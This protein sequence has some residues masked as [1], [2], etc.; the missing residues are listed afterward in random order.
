MKAIK[1]TFGVGVGLLACAALPAHAEAGSNLGFGLKAHI[2]PSSLYKHGKVT[3]P[4][5]AQQ[6]DKDQERG[7]GWFGKMP[8]YIGGYVEYAFTDFLGLELGLAYTWQGGTFKGKEKKED[9][10]NPNAPGASTTDPKAPST[11]KDTY[12]KVSTHGLYVPLSLCIYPMRREEG[13]W[14]MKI[15][16]GPS[17]YFPFS[18]KL[19]VKPEGGEEHTVD[20]KL[21]SFGFGAHGGVT[22]EFPFGLAVGV[23][24]HWQFTNVFKDLKKNNQQGGQVQGKDDDDVAELT[25]KDGK[26]DKT[27]KVKG[28]SKAWYATPFTLTLGY[29]FGALFNA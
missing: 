4:D 23:A 15:F 19:A 9:D 12:L 1:K 22:F 8:G 18:K 24:T 26:N 14:F 27:F 6:P 20:D 29:N 21:N 7:T 5:C 25:Y 11:S 28:L 3:F 10:K 17:V 13:E 2:G 16:L